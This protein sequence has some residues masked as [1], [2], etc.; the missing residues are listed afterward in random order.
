MDRVLILFF[1]WQMASDEEWHMHEKL[2]CTKFFDFADAFL[3][4]SGSKIANFRKKRH[5]V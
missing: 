3:L 5:V 2:K 4:L 1:I